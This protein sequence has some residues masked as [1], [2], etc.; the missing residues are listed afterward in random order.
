MTF[1]MESIADELQKMSVEDRLRE[2]E[3]LAL[4]L[5][6]WHQQSEEEQLYIDLYNRIKQEMK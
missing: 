5:L 6:D 4:N 3:K 1:E 2:L